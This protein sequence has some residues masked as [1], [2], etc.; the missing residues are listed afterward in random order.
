M[1]RERHRWY[2]LMLEQT[3][4]TGL[5]WGTE[6]RN[7]HVHCQGLLARQ[8]IIRFHR[9]PSLAHPRTGL[10]S[11][12]LRSLGGHERMYV[13]LADSQ[14]KLISYDVLLFF[15]SP[16]REGKQVRGTCQGYPYPQG[17]QAR[18]PST[19]QLLRQTLS[20]FVYCLSNLLSFL[21]FLY[22]PTL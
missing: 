7:P 9:R 12:C 1:S 16:T 5:L 6:T 8:R 18:Y 20:V 15:F 11:V 13:F 4:W 10:P 17:S 19:R 14:M 3:S 2:L 22:Y 21:S